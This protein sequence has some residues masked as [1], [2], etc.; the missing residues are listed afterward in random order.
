MPPTGLGSLG[1]ENILGLTAHMIVS[2]AELAEELG[3]SRPRVSQMIAKGLPVRADQR[4]DLAAACA[5]VIDN[6]DVCEGG[7][8]RGHAREW[9]HLL[10]R[11]ESR[12]Q[13]R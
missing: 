10:G 8:A 4:V 9:L 6:V 12:S 7:R 3:V 13:S 2:K 5:W 11:Q 1:E